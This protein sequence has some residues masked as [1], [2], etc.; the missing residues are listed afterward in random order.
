MSQRSRLHR[1]RSGITSLSELGGKEVAA[2]FIRACVREIAES[3]AV[4]RQA[5]AA[6]AA[7]NESAQVFRQTRDERGIAECL[8]GFAKV[9]RAENDAERAARLFGAAESLHK[10]VGPR[11][12]PV[13]H[14]DHARVVAE[15]RSA[16]GE[17][18]SAA[19]WAEGRA[20]TWGQAVAY[21]LGE[22]VR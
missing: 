14:H 13:D 9:A 18:A 15:A 11:L 20:M 2:T 3:C 1:R 10:I 12:S 8:A 21:A 6:R 5:D 16:L 7:L 17:E 22:T 19:A 4:C